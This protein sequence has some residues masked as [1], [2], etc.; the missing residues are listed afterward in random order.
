MKKRKAGILLILIGVGIPLV[1]F[2]FQDGGDFDLG[3]WNLK[4]LERELTLE[5]IKMI[6]SRIDE[7]LEERGPLVEWLIQRGVASEPGKDSQI[8][9]WMS[10][11]GPTETYLANLLGD[12]DFKS[13]QWSIT[14]GKHKY[15][16][17]KY[18]IGIG[19]ILVLFGFGMLIFSFFPK[20]E[21]A[22]IRDEDRGKEG[23]KP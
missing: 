17:Y 23:L 10:P 14:T 7:I 9:R 16:P 5:E 11:I 12:K 8:N 1:L 22:N 2:F 4:T 15:I 3:N 13:Q 6:K 18:S 20:E 19:I 21:K